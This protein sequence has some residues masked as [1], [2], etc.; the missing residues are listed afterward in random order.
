MPRFYYHFSGQFYQHFIKLICAYILSP[1]EV[2][3]IL[4]NVGTKNI[5]AKL[6]YQK[7]EHKMLVKLTPKLYSHFPSF[8]PLSFSPSHETVLLFH[9]FPLL[10]FLILS[11][12]PSSHTILFY[13]S[14]LSHSLVSYNNLLS[15]SS[16]DLPLST[17]SVSLLS[18][19]VIWWKA[20]ISILIQK[21]A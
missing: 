17:V 19:S 11:N 15:Y 13:L 21:F 14:L 9:P 7:D 20:S 16:L 6:S 12:P 4:Y 5:R 2:Q 8:L 18:I 3:T 10:L 1:K